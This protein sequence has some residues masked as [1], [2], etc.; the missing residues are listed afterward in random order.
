MLNFNNKTDVQKCLPPE[1][2]SKLTILLQESGYITIKPKKMDKDEWI[3]INDAVNHMGG[4]WISK[5]ELSH[6]S[7]PYTQ[8]SLNYPQSNLKM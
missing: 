6:W 1:L 7:I 4:Q 8:K 2:I 3:M 5:R